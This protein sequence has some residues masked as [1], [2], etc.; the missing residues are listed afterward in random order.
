[1][2]IQIELPDDLFD[3]DQTARLKTLFNTPDDG[4]FRDALTRVT[5]A[6]L[7]EYRDMFLGM[8]MPSRADEIRQHRLFH[9]I[10]HY[11]RDRVPSEADV[12][13]MFQLAQR[14]SRRLIGSVITRFR[15]H[16]AD[17]LSNTLRE[18][19]ESAQ[20]Q[21]DGSYHVVIQSDNA[22]DELNLI[23]G[24]NAPGCDPIAK[25][26]N[27]ART[28]TIAPDSNQAL[29]AYLSLAALPE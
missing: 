5:C 20:G 2:P 13:A 18:I 14:E 3:D 22:V 7:T 25:V 1:M 24:I 16:L 27:M 29:R 8:P 4:A 11:F 21:A 15:F 10:K 26:R 28:Y 19:V 17:E 12:S 9:L 6:A 23:I